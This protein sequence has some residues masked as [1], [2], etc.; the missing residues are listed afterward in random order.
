[1]LLENQLPL[2]DKLFLLLLIVNI[3]KST[4][5]PESKR[6]TVKLDA[7]MA[8]VPSANRHNTEFAANAINAKIVNTNVLTM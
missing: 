4:R 2:E 6:I 1:M 3:A 7:S 5:A 8:S